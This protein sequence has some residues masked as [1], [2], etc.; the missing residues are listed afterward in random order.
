MSHAMILDSLVSLNIND[1]FI[2]TVFFS[3]KRELYRNANDN[4]FSHPKLSKQ[5]SER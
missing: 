3:C 1:I 2:S 5:T 4:N